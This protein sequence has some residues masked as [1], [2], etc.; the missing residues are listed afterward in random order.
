M[1]DIDAVSVI[2][3]FEYWENEEWT[4]N[5]NITFVKEAGPWHSL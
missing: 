4:K 5:R 3:A 1:M 2:T